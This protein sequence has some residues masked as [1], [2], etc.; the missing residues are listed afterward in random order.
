[1][2]AA[3][4]V[5]AIT[6]LFALAA[7]ASEAPARAPAVDPNAGARIDSLNAK[8]S[9]VYRA[10]DSRAYPLLFT[11]SAVFEWPAFETVRGRPGLEAL[12]R[13]GWKPLDDLALRVIPSKRFIGADHATEF[14]AFEESWRDSTGARKTEYGRYAEV[15]ARQPDGSWLIDHYFGFEDSTATRPRP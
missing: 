15:L 8:L 3:Q 9:A 6:S 7:C 1:M 12:A 13:D 10:R 14:G 5:L 2:I 11:D 4:R